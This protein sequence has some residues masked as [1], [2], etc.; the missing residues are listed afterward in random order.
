MTADLAV[1]AA[2]A[3]LAQKLAAAGVTVHMLVNRAAIGSS[4][5]RITL[6]R[7]HSPTWRSTHKRLK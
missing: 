1:P 7:R 4:S 3:E 6:W 2:A 5:W